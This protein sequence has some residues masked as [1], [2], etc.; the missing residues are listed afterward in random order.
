MQSKLLCLLGLVFFLVLA[1]APAEARRVALVIGNDNYANLS[2]LDN[3][4]PDA[5][6]IAAVLKAHGFEVFEHY[7]ITRA[8]LLD[9]L[10]T[11]KQAADQSTAA[12]I[13]YAGHGMELAGKNIIA[14]TD[15]E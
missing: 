13:Y 14:P 9:A 11:F 10:E 15:M 4:V 7:D 2:K 1:A 6:A 3:P 12:L 5:K 8:D